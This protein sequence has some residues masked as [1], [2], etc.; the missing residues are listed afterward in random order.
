MPRCSR[1]STS[2]K[3][4]RRL[5]SSP[6]STSTLAAGQ[7]AEDLAE[8][9]HRHGRDAPRL[10]AAG[11]GIAHLGE[12]QRQV[13]LLQLRGAV[14]GQVGVEVLP[15]AA[16]RL[17]R[18]RLLPGAA[19]RAW[20]PPRPASKCVVKGIAIAGD[21]RQQRGQGV[22]GVVGG[23]AAAADAGGHEDRA[24]QHRRRLAQQLVRGPRPAACSTRSS[25][26]SSVILRTT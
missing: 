11:L 14:A 18:R 15:G 6:C 19:G 5:G 17:A 8:Q 7:P 12:E 1:S 24:G 23:R 9:P 2:G 3:R 22:G 25:R 16:E 4:R 13:A 20:A 10:V 21:A 26:A